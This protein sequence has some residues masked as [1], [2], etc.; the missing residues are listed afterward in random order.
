MS[1]SQAQVRELQAQLHVAQ[2]RARFFQ[3]E[4]VRLRARVHEAVDEANRRF[5]PDLRELTRRR[6][7]SVWADEELEKYWSGRNSHVSTLGH[8][9]LQNLVDRIKKA[10]E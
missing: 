1:E 7:L 5:A 2:M 8:A 9:I 10:E 6:W 3:E 4:N